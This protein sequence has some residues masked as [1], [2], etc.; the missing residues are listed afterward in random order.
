MV[1]DSVYEMTDY[2]K[3]PTITPTLTFESDF[4]S[5]SGWTSTDSKFAINTGQDAL[6][7]NN[8][9]VTDN[10]QIGYDLTS[11]SDTAWILDFDL[12]IVSLTSAG[13]M[14]THIGMFSVNTSVNDDQTQNFLGL[15]LLGENAQGANTNSILLADQQGGS[16]GGAGILTSGL[17]LT[18]TPQYYLR[19]KRTASNKLTIENYSSSARTGTPSTTVTRTL[20][21]NPQSLRYLKV[22]NR[23]VSGSGELNIKIENMKFYNGVTSLLPYPKPRGQHF[24]EY[25][26]GGSLNSRWSSHG[27]GSA[28]ITEDGMLL[29]S[30]TN[31]AQSIDLSPSD[32]GKIRPFSPT[33]A[34]MIVTSKLVQAQYSNQSNGFRT[35]YYTEAGKYVIMAI[36]GQTNGNSGDNKIQLK[37]NNPSTSVD[38]TLASS[39]IHDWHTYKLELLTASSTLNVDGLLQVTGSCN[40]DTRCQPYLNMA[41]AEGTISGGAKAN[42]R[43]CEV[44][45]T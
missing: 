4:T 5:T 25:F 3:S 21:D 16:L 26:S 45:N 24:W 13:S 34:V 10:L 6:I 14:W 35:N 42:Y 27:S 1:F 39:A 9:Q 22:S 29:T 7:A 2:L 40:P 11:I 12:K 17:T 32:A 30:P 15:I 36:Q 31:G 38:T 44:Y 8:D 19:L 37:S 33:G 41:T 20:G 18:G 23:T 43:Y 28:S